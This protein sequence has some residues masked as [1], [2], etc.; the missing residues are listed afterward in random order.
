M[1]SLKALSLFLVLSLSTSF[2]QEQ[3]YSVLFVIDIS[4][5]MMGA[6]LRNVK[7]VINKSVGKMP[8]GSYGGLISFEGCGDSKVTVE[9]P[10]S[11]NPHE[12]IK[13]KANALT[14]KG[15]TD[16][17][18]ALKKAAGEAKRLP[19]V[20]TNVI[21]LTDGMDT[22]SSESASSIAKK[23]ANVNTCN[24]VNVVSIGLVEDWEKGV[25][26]DISKMGKGKHK[27]KDSSEEVLDEV[28]DIVEAHLGNGSG[29]TEWNG[30]YNKPDNGDNGDNGDNKP[31]PPVNEKE[32]EEEEK[33]EAGSGS[34]S[35]DKKDKKD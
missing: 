4:G 7:N 26:D 2:A 27:P 9:V 33:A 5:S 13:A 23:I 28:V 32:E 14:A 17:V 18:R 22:C 10:I 19:T 8:V 11:L 24:E 34:S 29:N 1:K 6:P 12:S 31:P 35:N 16:L 30:D 15:S 21:V 3:G 20:C 25:M